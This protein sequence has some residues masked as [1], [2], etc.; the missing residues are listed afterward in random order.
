MHH[1]CFW[2]QRYVGTH[3]AAGAHQF[4]DKAPQRQQIRDGVPIQVGHDE[5]HP[6]SICCGCPELHLHMIERLIKAIIEPHSGKRYTEQV[7]DR[8]R[9]SLKEY[10]STAFCGV[11]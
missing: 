2:T 7:K 3:A 6:S 1:G 9:S 10:T 4:G 8:D 11:S 5:R